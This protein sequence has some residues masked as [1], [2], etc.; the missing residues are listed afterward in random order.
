MEE[1]HYNIIKAMKRQGGSFVVAL[2][3]AF[4]QA[5][6]INFNKL[7][8]TFDVYWK[9]YKKVAKEYGNFED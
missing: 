4:E 5:D 7:K 1:E 8:T 6:N 2:A 9:T 3:G